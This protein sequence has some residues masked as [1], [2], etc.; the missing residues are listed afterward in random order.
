MVMDE[1][2]P[3]VVVGASAIDTK[4]RASGRLTRGSSSHGRVHTNVGGV[5]R[6]VAENL[7]RLG[8]PTRLL[9]AVGDD[10][11]GRQ[12]LDHGTESGIDLSRVLVSK[13]HRTGAYISIVEHGAGA[14]LPST[15][16]RSCRS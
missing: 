14:Y 5:A 15:T 3:V 9:S 10:A 4:G 1:Y 13:A 2:P 7:A 8:V 6:N 16:W 11:M 12:I